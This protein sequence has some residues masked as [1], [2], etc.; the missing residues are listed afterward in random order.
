MKEET[1]IDFAGKKKKRNE[2]LIHKNIAVALKVRI[3]VESV[4]GIT[5]LRLQPCVVRDLHYT[6]VLSTKNDGKTN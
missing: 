1:H 3:T 2:L 6:D 5:Q 4:N